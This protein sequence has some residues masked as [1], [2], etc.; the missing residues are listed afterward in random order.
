[1]TFIPA[2]FAMLPISCCNFL[3]FYHILAVFIIYILLALNCG[4]RISCIALYGIFQQLFVKNFC[5]LLHLSTPW[6]IKEFSLASVALEL[7]KRLCVCNGRWSDLILYTCVCLCRISMHPFTAN[8]W[9]ADSGDR[10]IWIFAVCFF[11]FLFFFF[12]RHFEYYMSA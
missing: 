6:L 5:G 7:T 8:W 4:A 3:P 10:L 9:A 1:M 11:L 2:S 12:R